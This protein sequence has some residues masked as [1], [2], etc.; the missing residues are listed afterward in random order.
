[1]LYIYVP[2]NRLKRPTH[3]SHSPRSTGQRRR[4][5]SGA[6]SSTC[7]AATRSAPSPQAW[8]TVPSPAST[9]MRCTGAT[10]P[11]TIAASSTWSPSRHAAPP[12]T[13]INA[14]ECR[15]PSTSSPPPGASASGAKPR[16]LDR[17]VMRETLY[18][19]IMQRHRKSIFALGSFLRM[20]KT[21]K[22]NYNVIKQDGES[23]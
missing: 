23:E 15:S 16:D 3:P 17:K 1:M 5:T 21:K 11:A 18:S 13:V 2:P 6:S 14:M 10:S 20:L 22:S 8:P 7:T 4:T 9:P 19:E 12:Y